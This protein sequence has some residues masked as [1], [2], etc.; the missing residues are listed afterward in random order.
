MA[1]RGPGQ[2]ER[3]KADEELAAEIAEVHAGH[4][5]PTGVADRRRAAAAAVG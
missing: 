1:C 3:A 5:A 2:A 4:R